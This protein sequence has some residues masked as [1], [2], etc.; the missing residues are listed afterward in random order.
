MKYFYSIF[1][2]FIF[3]FQSETP[4]PIL[5]SLECATASNLARV[6]P[7]R[8]QT[9]ELPPNK[10]LLTYCKVDRRFDVAVKSMGAPA[11]LLY[12]EPG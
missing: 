12:V 2:F 10:W 3:Y 4:W 7:N 1:W 5:A 8:I 6:N 9:N 11:K